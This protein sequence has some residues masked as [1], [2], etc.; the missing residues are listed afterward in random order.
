MYLKIRWDG[1]KNF[2]WGTKQGLSLGVWLT[3]GRGLGTWSGDLLSSLRF[4]E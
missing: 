2:G 1:R 3:V 4:D